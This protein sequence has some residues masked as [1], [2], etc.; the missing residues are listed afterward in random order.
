[1]SKTN[2]QS[3]YSELLDLLAQHKSKLTAMKLELVTLEGQKATLG[4]LAID[5]YLKKSSDYKDR[6][7]AVSDNMIATEDVK[8]EIGYQENTI[9][10]TEEAVVEEKKKELAR[11]REKY[12]PLYNEAVASST[13]RC[14]RLRS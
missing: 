13:R 6:K 2:E 12:Q 14:W 10:K 9:A 4:S 1:M 7:E 8:R 5:A 3:P 11:I